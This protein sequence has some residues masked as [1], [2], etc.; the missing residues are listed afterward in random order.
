MRITE[1]FI[2]RETYFSSLL[3]VTLPS[4]AYLPASE[5][6][7][8]KHAGRWTETFKS[9][10]TQP[11]GARKKIRS[12]RFYILESHQKV[13]YKLLDATEGEKGGRGEGE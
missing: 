5:S 7:R 8:K 4:Q 9:Q 13:K 1:E 11:S 12:C 10:H 6:I 2:E 3:K